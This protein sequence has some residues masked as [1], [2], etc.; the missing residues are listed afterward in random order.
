MAILFQG[1]CEDELVP[2]WGMSFH[3]KEASR[4]GEKGQ[5]R[6]QKLK[7]QL[8]LCYWPALDSGVLTR[9]Q[10][11]TFCKMSI[12]NADCQERS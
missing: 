11:F 9:H 10:V 12:T 2:V 8:C 6:G 7:S 3:C 4:S 1:H 5:D